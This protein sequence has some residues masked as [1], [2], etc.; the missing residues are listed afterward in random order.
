M[1]PLKNDTAGRGYCGPTVVACLTGRSLSEVLDVI[2]AGR[3]HPTDSLGRKAPVRSTYSGELIAAFRT[4]GWRVVEAHRF[5]TNPPTLARWLRSR[6]PA[7]RAQTFVVEV[8]GH[9]VAVSGRKVVDTFTKGKPVWLKDAPDRRKRVHRTWT[10]T[11][12]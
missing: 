4:F 1:K 7:E 6:S 10:V 11:K 5:R 9:W 8:T 12:I 2:R 3:C